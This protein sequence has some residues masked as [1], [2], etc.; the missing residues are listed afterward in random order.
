[1]KQFVFFILNL[2]SICA[3]SASLEEI[4]N[5][6]YHIIN[7]STLE[8]RNQKIYTYLKTDDLF[9]QIDREAISVF[10]INL[11]AKLVKGSSH[12]YDVLFQLGNGLQSRAKYYDAY[13]YLYKVMKAIQN[14]K[15][16]LK[17]MCKYHKAMGSIYFYFK[18]Y[19]QSEKQFYAS[20]KCA[21]ISKRDL[22]D[23]YNTL[24]LSFNA[25]NNI[26]KAEIYFRRGIQLAKEINDEAWFGVL[27]GNLGNL[28]YKKKNYAKAVENLLIDYELSTKNNQNSSALNALGLLIEINIR[29]KNKDLAKKQLHQLDSLIHITDDKTSYLAYYRAKTF[30]L[31]EIGNYKE[32]F[33]NYKSLIKVQDSL[34]NEKDLQNIF[35]T[36]FQIEFERKQAEIGVLTESKKAYKNRLNYLW[37]ILVISLFGAT[38]TIWQINKRKKKEKE[39]LEIKNTQMQN[40]LSQ[41]EKELRSVVRKLME[42]N[43]MIQELSDEIEGF[44][45]VHESVHVEKAA[46]TNRLQSFTL[47]TEEDWLDFKRLFE[48]CFPKFFDYFQVNFPNITNAEIRL[49]ALI[50]L[51]LENTEMAN[52]LGISPDSVRKTNLRLRKKLQI[53]DQKELLKFIK[54]I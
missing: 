45:S 2:L 34:K 6:I 32:A 50:K 54:D 14:E 47:L 20:I 49:A 27:S 48:K 40:E 42:K 4:N 10:A 19:T 7:E 9:F 29:Q 15:Y 51:D 3:Y 30:Y 28:Y 53:S 46:L 13:P 22:L 38:I 5:E 31:E 33:Q 26:D 44:Q 11:E 43:N 41:S 21:D 16:A 52:A 17:D 12:Y 39:L 24:G 25:R 36:E 37:I 1:M 18:R 35:N 8:N 23:I